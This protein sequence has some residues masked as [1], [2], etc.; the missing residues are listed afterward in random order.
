VIVVAV[1]TL[2]VFCL[3]DYCLLRTGS[4]E[5]FR[6]RARWYSLS[7]FVTA[8]AISLA[9]LAAGPVAV[10]DVILSR[11][12]LGTGIVFHLIGAALCIWLRKRGGGFGHGWWISL[13][14]APAPWIFLVITSTS[15]FSRGEGTLAGALVFTVG[16]VW[17]VS[18]AEGA[19]RAHRANAAGDELDFYVRFAGW[20]NSMACCLVPLIVQG[21]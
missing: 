11:W 21:S 20:S 4:S 13:V 19:T 2:I 5:I 16:T 1:C 10:R 8:A 12:L 7:V 18:I 17:A 14:P 15:F 6:R 3:R 9:L